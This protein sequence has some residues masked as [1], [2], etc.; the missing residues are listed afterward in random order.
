MKKTYFI[1]FLIIILISS[2]ITNAKEGDIGGVLSSV[3]L[4][5]GATFNLVAISFN[6]FKMPVYLGGKTKI[7][8]GYKNKKKINLWFLSDWMILVIPKLWGK[9]GSGWSFTFSI[10]DVFITIGF[11][12]SWFNYL[13]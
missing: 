9:Q 11:I 6:K 10:G 13:V 3:L 5:V 2:L 7:H 8:F 1:P 4:I 12:L